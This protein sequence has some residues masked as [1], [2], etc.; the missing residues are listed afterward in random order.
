MSRVFAR[1]CRHACQ[2]HDGYRSALR[3][4]RTRRIPDAR[5]M[6]P[7][8]CAD[9]CSFVRHCL[10]VPAY[11]SSI[12]CAYSLTAVKGRCPFE[13][14]KA[15]TGLHGMDM[16]D[17]IRQTCLGVRL[18]KTPEEKRRLRELAR[19]GANLNQ[20]ARWANET[21]SGWL[22][23]TRSLQNRIICSIVNEFSKR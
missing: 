6:R 2:P 1:R 11:V 3:P 9:A 15:K 17:Y 23:F 14:R 21:F 20:L 13:P 22:V 16:S 10:R 5:I 19:I 8:F 12:R 18:R 4:I 7:R